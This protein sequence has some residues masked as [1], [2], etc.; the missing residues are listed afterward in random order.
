MPRNKGYIPMD[1]KTLVTLP[2]HLK[3]ENTD[4]IFDFGIIASKLKDYFDTSSTSKTINELDSHIN[5]SKKH[6]KKL[7]HK[8]RIYIT[9]NLDFVSFMA[10]DFDKPVLDN[11]V[12]TIELLSEYNPYDFAGNY[13]YYPPIIW[14]F[15]DKELVASHIISPKLA[16][17]LATVFV[18]ENLLNKSAFRDSWYGK[19][20]RDYK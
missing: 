1:L 20:R 7:N 19:P 9:T 2:V 10:V 4:V 13:P 3:E 18:K 11:L 17:E 16:I 5:F 14:V 6:S 12:Y 8:N 15:E